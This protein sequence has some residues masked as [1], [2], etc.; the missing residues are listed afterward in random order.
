[1]NGYAAAAVGQVPAMLN[2]YGGP[3]GVLGRLIGIGQAEVKAGVPWWGWV[4]V[5]VVLGGV[6]TYAITN[7]FK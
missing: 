3:V 2:R 1:M 6:A 5:G 4:G 7:K